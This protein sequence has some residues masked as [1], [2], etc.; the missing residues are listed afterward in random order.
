MNHM[1]NPVTFKDKDYSKIL[2][3]LSYMKG[4]A[5]NWAEGFIVSEDIEEM[6]WKTFEGHLNKALICVADART[7][8]H[9]VMNNCFDL[10]NQTTQKAFV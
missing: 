2:N 5:S 4:K 8:R 3:I 1:G 7:A 9:K 10:C 6:D